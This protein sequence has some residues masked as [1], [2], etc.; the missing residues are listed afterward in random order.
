ME[1]LVSKKD[2]KYHLHFQDAETKLGV[3]ASVTASKLREI[4]RTLIKVIATDDDAWED[5][6]C[7][8][9]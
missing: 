8:R 4:A 6:E 9:S 3:S 1:F 5:E 7:Q 2:G